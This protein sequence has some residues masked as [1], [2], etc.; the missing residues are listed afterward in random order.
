MDYTPEEKAE[1]EALQRRLLESR[2]Y[3]TAFEDHEL[4]QHDSLRP[5]RLA[6]ELI[7]PELAQQE[8][9]VY[10][11]IVVFGSARTLPLDVATRS[12]EQA[13]S[14]A[15]ANP[16]DLAA[17]ETHKRARKQVE[18]ARYYEVARAFARRVSQACQTC[19]ECDYVVVTGG[20]PGIMEAGNRGAHDIGAKS[21]GLNI[22]LP[23]EQSPNPYISPE[24][25]FD[26]RYYA[27]RK[28]H[29]LIRAK[30]LITFPGG[31]GTFDELFEVL[32]LIQTEKVPRIPVILVGRAFW[33]RV[34][35][36][37]ALADEGVISPEDLDLISYAE[38]AEE[39][40][41]IIA[42]FHGLHA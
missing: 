29:F 38:E 24:L 10:S 23:F 4:M 25:C 6:L 3:V 28:M 37:P 15:E 35:N 2:A 22:K 30:A 42:R 11:T 41:S 36:L 21:I 34:V 39:I 26:F 40:W 31:F 17:R 32:T 27:I 12:L 33:E 19:D 5:V 8:Q 1:R 20:G 7:K 13:R 9:R 14:Q 18:Q 16:T